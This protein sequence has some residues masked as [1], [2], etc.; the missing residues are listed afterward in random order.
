M[1]CIV[2]SN[3]TTLLCTVDETAP[4]CEHLVAHRLLIPV[5][6]WFSFAVI[7]SFP[8]L[9]IRDR[10]F[11][12]AGD[13][14]DPAPQPLPLTGPLP[15]FHFPVNPWSARQTRSNTTDSAL[16]EPDDRP[17]FSFSSF[18]STPYRRNLLKLLH[19]HHSNTPK[20][21]PPGPIS[22]GFFLSIQSE[23]N[24]MSCNL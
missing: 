22:G 13:A 20:R 3:Y 11:A 10:Y 4:K 7:L 6:P 17:Y 23:K 21:F 16:T 14:Y 15:A 12:P 8:G 24:Y 5:A 2:Y 1:P 19:H 18:F 9:N